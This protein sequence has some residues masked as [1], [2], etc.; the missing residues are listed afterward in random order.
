MANSYSGKRQI[1]RELNHIADH[2]D[3]IRGA[4]LRKDYKAIDTHAA[5]AHG[6]VKT[7]QEREMKATRKY[8]KKGV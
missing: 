8:K 4:L 1:C 2:L 3:A 6:M 5:I 7:A